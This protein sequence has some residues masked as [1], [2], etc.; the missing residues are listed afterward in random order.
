MHFVTRART[1]I[2]SL[3]DK[4]IAGNIFP[5]KALCHFERAILIDGEL[6]LRIG[7]SIDSESEK[8]NYFRLLERCLFPA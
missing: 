5:V 6:A 2:E 4:L 1:G 7:L 3:D 8:S